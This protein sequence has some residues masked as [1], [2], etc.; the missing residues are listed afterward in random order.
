[1]PFAIPKTLRQAFPNHQEAMLLA[2]KLVKYGIWYIVFV[3]LGYVVGA[4]H[5]HLVTDA[6]IVAAVFFWT[7][8]WLVAM[9]FHRNRQRF[10]DETAG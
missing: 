9:K 5:L 4:F 1:M 7:L 3:A 2:D 6:V 8:Y 10:I